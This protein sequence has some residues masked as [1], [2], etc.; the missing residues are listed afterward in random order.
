MLS[1]TFQWQKKTAMFTV[2]TENHVLKHFLTVI[3]YMI[4]ELI[5]CLLKHENMHVIT[6]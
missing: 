2:P 5:F 3:V 6:Q 1:L 4:L